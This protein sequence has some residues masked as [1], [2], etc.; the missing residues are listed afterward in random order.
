MAIEDR[1]PTRAN[2]SP[3]QSA[4]DATSRQPWRSDHIESRETDTDVANKEIA[5][6]EV[7]VVG[8][9]PERAG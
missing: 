1:V 7:E 3:A 5:K 4:G 8:K 6:P 2:P 9:R